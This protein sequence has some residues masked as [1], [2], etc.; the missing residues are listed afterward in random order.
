MAVEQAIIN[1]V[2]RGQAE[3]EAR[4]AKIDADLTALTRAAGNAETATRRVASAAS[5]AEQA[6]R[7]MSSQI[8]AIASKLSRA[9]AAVT[10][11]GN[12][13]EA[14]GAG[15]G[16]SDAGQVLAGIAAGGATG[17]QL[18]SVVPGLGTALGAGIGAIAG[19]GIAVYNVM[20]RREKEEV[21]ESAAKAA[22][23]GA[24]EA[25]RDELRKSLAG[26]AAGTPRDDI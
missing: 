25:T 10:L 16:I 1:F 14:A 20:S 21:V 22:S 26:I 23:A 2:V 17:A 3:L 6:A 8:T 24:V 11:A 4:T 19:G 5:S 13:A 12:I 7:Q 9:A 15:R 18:G